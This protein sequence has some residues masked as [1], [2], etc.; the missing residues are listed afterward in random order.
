MSRA[1]MFIADSPPQLNKFF[2][3]FV[4]WFRHYLILLNNASLV[5]RFKNRLV[6]K[7]WKY[8]FLKVSPKITQNRIG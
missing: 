8:L 2:S 1:Y 4:A 3:V 6:G 5:K 7:G